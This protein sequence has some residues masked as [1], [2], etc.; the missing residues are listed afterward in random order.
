MVNGQDS[1]V[2]FVV[3][4]FKPLLRFLLV[5]E[6]FLPVVGR[7]RRTKNPWDS[8]ARKILLHDP[9]NICGFSSNV[10]LDSTPSS[11]RDVSGNSLQMDSAVAGTDS[12]STR[13]NFVGQN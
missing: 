10:R 9:R 6:N 12:T 5:K 7:W 13:H 8:G 11:C 1:V 4:I 3:R 2:E